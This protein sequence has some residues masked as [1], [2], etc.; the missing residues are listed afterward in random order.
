MAGP[1]TPQRDVAAELG[2]LLEAYRARLAGELETLAA[3]LHRARRDGSAARQAHE[4][5]HRLKG[6]S[7]TYGLRESSLALARI[8][9]L[10]AERLERCADPA[11]SWDEIRRELERAR[12]GLDDPASRSS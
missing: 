2:D 9:S 6:T 1:R 7:G 11:G 4:L 5:A 3:L 12:A 8:E 10:L